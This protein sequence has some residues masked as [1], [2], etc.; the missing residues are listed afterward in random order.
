MLFGIFYYIFGPILM[1]LFHFF[2]RLLLNLATLLSIYVFTNTLNTL[3]SSTRHRSG[4][5][6]VLQ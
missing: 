2:Q 5:R 6:Y 1:M 4:D 3:T